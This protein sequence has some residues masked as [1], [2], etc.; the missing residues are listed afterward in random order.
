MGTHSF[1][2][3]PP[4]F[5]GHTYFHNGHTHGHTFLRIA[6]EHTRPIRNKKTRSDAGLD[7]FYGS[8]RTALEG[9]LFSDAEARKDHAQQIVGAEFTGDLVE[10]VLGLS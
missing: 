9:L 10:G 2:G 7:R 4:I 3:T 8:R 5:H 1:P 6:V